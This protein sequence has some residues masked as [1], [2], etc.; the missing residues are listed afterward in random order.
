MVYVLKKSSYSYR[1][2]AEKR[3][4]Q[5]LAPMLEPYLLPLAFSL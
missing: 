4:P 3:V 5:N 1:Q 2:T